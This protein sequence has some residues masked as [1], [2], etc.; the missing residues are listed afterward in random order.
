M[1]WDTRPFPVILFHSD[2][3]GAKLNKEIILMRSAVNIL[4][5]AKLRARTFGIFTLEITIKR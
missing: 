2:F 4:G 3:V 5:K 1:E